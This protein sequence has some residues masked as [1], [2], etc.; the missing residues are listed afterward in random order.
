MPEL[1]EA[2]KRLYASSIRNHLQNVDPTNF[3]AVVEALK[4]K[5]IATQIRAMNACTHLIDSDD[6]KTHDIFRQ[7]IV[8]REETYKSSLMEK[9][10]VVK[11]DWVTILSRLKKTEYKK[12][13]EHR[14]YVM[15]VL[16]KNHPRRFSDYHFL[17]TD[18]EDAS[19]NPYDGKTIIFNKFKT[20][21]SMT[22]GERVVTVNAETREALDEYIKKWELVGSR[23]FDITRK[24]MRYIYEKN[25]LPLSTENRREQEN[26]DLSSGMSRVDA[27]Q[28]YNHSV[29]T[30]AVSYRV[31]D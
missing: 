22:G 28:K 19:M 31:T 11:T 13:S 2:S 29:A 23:L 15:A 30:Q 7:A 6:K 3:N 9:R 12:I 16:L 4:D 26:A 5:P 27:S 10:K 24:Q 1:S 21:G 20:V 18:K 14:A 17:T 8:D 25:G